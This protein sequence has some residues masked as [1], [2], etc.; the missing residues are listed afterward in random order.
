L[1]SVSLGSAFVVGPVRAPIEAEA[2]EYADA[3]SALS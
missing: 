2:A 3:K 1:K